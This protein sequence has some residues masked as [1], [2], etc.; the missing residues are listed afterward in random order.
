MYLEILSPEKSIFKG[1]VYGV[2]LPGL[3]GYF[4][5]LQHHAPLIATLGK[6]RVKVIKDKD[7][8]EFFQISGGFVEVL[9]NK[10]SVLVEEVAPQE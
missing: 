7:T 6:G 2:Q 3:E 4:E 8:Q 1:K 9:Q 10:A 5:I